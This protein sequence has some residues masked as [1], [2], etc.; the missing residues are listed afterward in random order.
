[1]TARETLWLVEACSAA[2]YELGPFRETFYAQTEAQ[3]IDAFEAWMIE[4]GLDEA[5]APRAR[6]LRL[7]SPPLYAHLRRNPLSP[8]FAGDEEPTRTP[9][10]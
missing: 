1:M 9:E 4:T 8:D 6:A 7:P 5:V 3:A 2:H 10:I